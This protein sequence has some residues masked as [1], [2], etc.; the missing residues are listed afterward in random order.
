MAPCSGATVRT[1]RGANPDQDFSRVSRRLWIQHPLQGVSARRTWAVLLLVVILA[2][3][4]ASA[5]SRSAHLA[6]QTRQGVPPPGE[7]RYGAIVPASGSVASAN[8]SSGPDTICPPPPGTACVAIILPK[9]GSTYL[10]SIDIGGLIVTTNQQVYVTENDPTDLSVYSLASG[11]G[12]S[13]WGATSGISIAQFEQQSTT[14][15]VS[16]TASLL[17]NVYATNAAADVNFDVFYSNVTTGSS[18]GQILLEDHAFTGGQSAYL[19][20]GQQY[21]ISG[22]GFAAGYSFDQWASL[23]GTLGN[24]TQRSTTFTPSGGAVLA[25]IVNLT[26]SNWGGYIYSGASET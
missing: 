25:L 21:S 23:S 26:S 18:A 12:F 24:L 9:S 16:G 4:F 3:P 14:I 6:A 8:N 19:T 22:Q 13:F 15:V 7:P 1:P 5:G 10:G 20:A 17:L 2:V 11:Y